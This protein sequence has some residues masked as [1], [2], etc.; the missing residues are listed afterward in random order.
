MCV[1]ARAVFRGLVI[2]LR[3]SIERETIRRSFLLVAVC[4]LSV[5]PGFERWSSAKW[6][7]FIG[8]VVI[9]EGLYYVNHK[10]SSWFDPK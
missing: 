7:L 2:K 6:A 9:M 8:V 10:P 4:L 5:S 1:K 3:L